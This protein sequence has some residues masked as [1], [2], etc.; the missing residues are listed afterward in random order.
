M[1][2]SSLSPSHHHRPQN[3][4]RDTYYGSHDD[5]S[6][7]PAK[8]YVTHRSTVDDDRPMDSRGLQSI[9][10]KISKQKLAAGKN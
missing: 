2:A 4:H 8:T 7:D 1:F 9:Q 5:H 10:R 3:F 6:Y